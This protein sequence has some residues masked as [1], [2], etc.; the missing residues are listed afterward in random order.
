MAWFVLLVA[1]VAVERLAELVVARRNERWSRAHGAIEAGAGHRGFCRLFL[2]HRHRHCMDALHDG[3]GRA[4]WRD[5]SD[6][7]AH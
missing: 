5:D 7:H 2:G 3:R 1:L 6:P 4:S